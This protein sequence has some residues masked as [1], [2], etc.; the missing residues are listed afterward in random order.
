MQTS[1]SLC[2]D[3]AVTQMSNSSHFS[4]LTG[5]EAIRTQANMTLK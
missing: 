4:D 1:H 5:S 3:K 2:K